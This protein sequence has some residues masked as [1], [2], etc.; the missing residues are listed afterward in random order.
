MK[1]VHL[2]EEK[3]CGLNLLQELKIWPKMFRQKGS[4]GK[5]GKQIQIVGN[6]GRTVYQSATDVLMLCN[7]AD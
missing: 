6:K 1:N 5:H 7:K 2:E 4:G 3:V